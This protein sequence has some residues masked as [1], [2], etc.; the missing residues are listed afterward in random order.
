MSRDT[1]PASDAGTPQPLVDEVT[2]VLE[3]TFGVFRQART[4]DDTMARSDQVALHASYGENPHLSR[5]VAT[6][7]GGTR[8]FLVPARGTVCLLAESGSGGCPAPGTGLEGDFT[9]MHAA[10]DLAD[11]HVR[12]LGILPDGVAQIEVVSADGTVTSFP[13]QNNAVVADVPA[14]PLEAVWRDSKGTQRRSML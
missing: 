3:E 10:P 13:V 11:G 8:Y 9:T 2:A 5:H 7:N 14:D 1:N 4:S 12:V 6:S